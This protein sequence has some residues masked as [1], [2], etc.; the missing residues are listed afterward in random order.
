MT[1]GVK[2]FEK[3][4]TTEMWEGKAGQRTITGGQKK[5]KMCS[6]QRESL[7]TRGERGQGRRMPHHLKSRKRD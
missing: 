3:K 1:A 6:R 4:K 2:E 7:K 5:L